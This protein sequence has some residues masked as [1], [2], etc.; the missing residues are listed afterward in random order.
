MVEGSEPMNASAPTKTSKQTG[1]PTS[2]AST[3]A[4][5]VKQRVIGLAID[6]AVV[7]M[8][9]LVLRQVVGQ[10][11]MA[12][13]LLALLSVAVFAIVQGET[14]VSPGKAMT[15]L[16]LVND[17]GRPPG[18]VPA[19]IRLAAWAV[20]GLPCVGLFGVLLIWFTPTHQRVGDTITRTFVVSTRTDGAPADGAAVAP[21]PGPAPERYNAIGEDRQD[22]DPIW[23]G[24][25]EAYVQWDPTEKRWMKFDEPS[26]DW[27]P[28]EPI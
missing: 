18:A 13:G 3:E 25:V 27:V 21:A 11:V 6:G 10:G 20:D 23:D 28:V 19:L 14:G 7:T 26:G 12:F 2:P 4:T 9:W 24:K 1:K 8:T 22:F 5:L 16:K 15:G 17:R